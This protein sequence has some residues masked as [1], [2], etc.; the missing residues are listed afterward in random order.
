MIRSI[1]EFK[2]MC[3]DIG[4]HLIDGIMAIIVSLSIFVSLSFMKYCANVLHFSTDASVWCG[5]GLFMIVLTGVLLIEEKVHKDD[6]D[7]EDDDYYDEDDD[8]YYE[9]EDD[10]DYDEEVFEAYEQDEYEQYEEILS[11]EDYEE[12]EDG[13]V[14]VDEDEDYYYYES[15]DEYTD[16]EEGEL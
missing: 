2:E 10:D 6:I 15:V 8:Y 3:E 14:L 13:Y 11:N 12:D 7:D 4:F 1:R 5:F 9:D 16:E